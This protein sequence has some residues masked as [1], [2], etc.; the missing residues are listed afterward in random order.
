[1]KNYLEHNDEVR[2]VDGLLANSQEWNWF[3]ELL[4]ET[5]DFNDICNWVDF[6]GSYLQ[7]VF[8]KCIRVL[9]VYK[10]ELIVKNPLLKEIVEIGKFFLSIISVDACI[11][12][13]SFKYSRL[14]LLIVWV[15]KLEN[16]TN[17]NKYFTDIRLFVERNAWEIIDI[18]EVK[19]VEFELFEYINSIT[20]NGFTEYA[21]CFR[22]NIL[23]IKYPVSN[24]FID[25]YKRNLYS[26]NAFSYQY[27]DKPA[28]L[29]WQEEYILDM[30]RISIKNGDVTPTVSGRGFEDP[31]AAVW[32]VDIIENIKEYF[33]NDIADF[34]LDT[35]NYIKNDVQ[36]NA[37][38]L[39]MHCQLLSEYIDSAEN[40]CEIVN[41]STF[42]VLKWA[43]RKK[44][45]SVLRTNNEYIQFVKKLYTIDSHY[46]QKALYDA[47]YPLSKGQ[48]QQ[49]KQMYAE[50]Y[51]SIEKVD[52]IRG[53]I[54]YFR[55]NDIPKQITTEYL[56]MVADKF[57]RI[58]D[59]DDTI[60]VASLFYEYMVFLIKSNGKNADKRLV[61]NEMI[62]IQNIWQAKYYDKQSEKLGRYSYSTSIHNTDVKMFNN[63]ILWNPIR[64]AEQC[65]VIDEE[66]II[67]VMEDTAEN[68]FTYIFNTML[69]LPTF[70]ESGDSIDYEHHEI[71]LEIKK[72]IA[73]INNRMAY[74]FLNDVPTEVY[75]L[76]L[77]KRY[78]YCVE[79]TAALFHDEE[80]LY[81]YLQKC[82][83]Y[84][85]LPF[86]QEIKL[87]HL[88]QLFPALEINIRRLGSMLGVVPF[89]ES[90][91]G[92]GKF[93]DSSS[94][95]REIILDVKSEVGSFEN[96]PD[97]LFVYNC[98]Y[99]GNSINIRNDCLHG[100]Y[101]LTGG[102]LSLA[103]KITLLSL[104][105][106]IYRI[107]IIY[108]NKK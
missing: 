14:L 54:C 4:E 97:L 47:S 70:P 76:A 91:K 106:I 101:Y 5:Y 43:Y 12:K 53:L 38:V 73:D 7:Q 69:L 37:K 1:M 66:S 50:Q 92:F 18:S 103:F 21:Q 94:V 82:I 30:L 104:Y 25:K 46:L 57:N 39:L 15:T 22:N 85:L 3:V 96:I 65:M 67:K 8:I 28:I 83:D 59:E 93:K 19:L 20:V 17:D 100:R 40:E 71:E 49:I 35:V 11:E 33:L 98:M 55:N 6:R 78:K 23:E 52:N 2:F 68:P 44:D 24:G 107:N 88:T 42:E 102:Q 63:I 108:G 45:M 87:A 64:F 32:N 41:S 61:K 89:K 75:M 81:C 58:I 56:K 51:K 60:Q 26:V 90:I 99:N 72:M 31:N 74:R 34:V 10:G 48:K 62:R 80:K 84:E 29:S 27:I 13:V 79:T 86:E 105:M 9:E 77:Y 95:L 36:P 16:H